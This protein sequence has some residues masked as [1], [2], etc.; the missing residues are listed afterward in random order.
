VEATR[1]ADLKTILHSKRANLYYLE[2]CRALVH[3][4]RVEYVADAGNKS[5]YWN[6]SNLEYN[7]RGDD[8]QAFRRHCIEALTR[9][10]SLDFMIDTLEVIA[11]DV[12]AP[13]APSEARR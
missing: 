12:I 11:T 7:Q 4:G 1:P 8:E 9:D 3:G 10:E 5:L 6:I 2:H 13:E